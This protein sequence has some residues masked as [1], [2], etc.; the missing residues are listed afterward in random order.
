MACPTERLQPTLPSHQ[1]LSSP[2]HFWKPLGVACHRWHLQGAN[3]QVS[4][5]VDAASQVMVQA[6]SLSDPCLSTSLAV[7][8]QPGIYP[9][10]K[11]SAVLLCHIESERD[12]YKTE[13]HIVLPCPSPSDEGFGNTHPLLHTLGCPQQR[14]LLEFL[15]L[16]KSGVQAT[17]EFLHFRLVILPLPAEP[18]QRSAAPSHRY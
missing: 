5:R 10:L 18:R 13:N 11:A 15:Q 7:N 17:L 2:R 1:E 12:R 4:S 3:G 6:V 8:D 9:S 14:K 16:L